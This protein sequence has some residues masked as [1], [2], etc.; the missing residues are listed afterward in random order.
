MD[1]RLI[2]TMSPADL[3]RF[4]HAMKQ[5]YKFTPATLAQ[6]I[7][8]GRWIAAR[9]L[10]YISTIVASEVNKGNA[11]I[12]VCMPARH[13]KSEFLSV[14]T[15]I[16]FLEKWPHK[17]VMNLS[18]GL[19][20]ASE[21]SL[22]VRTAF[23]DEDN[24]D[25]LNTRLRKDKLKI[26]RFMTT[27]NGGVTAAGIGGVITGRGADLLLV[28]DYIK[29]AEA[30]LSETQN[31][32]T[33]EWFK[34]TAYTRLEPGAS[35]IVLATRWGI[36]DLIGRLLKEMAHEN[37]IVIN[38]PAFA[39]ENDPLG[40]AVGEPLWPERYPTE[41]LNAIKAS[42]GAYWWEAMFQQNPR[43]SMAGADLGEQIRV[44]EESEM[45]PLHLL[46]S[47]RAWD[48]AA[49][50]SKGDYTAG[51]LLSYYPA[52]G[53]FYI[54]D[55]QHLQASPLGVEKRVVSMA[56]A[57]GPGVPI[58]LE[59]EPGSSGVIVID[60]YRRDVLTGYSVGGDKP[61]GRIEVRAS[62]LMADI[63]AGLVSMVRAPWNDRLKEE[64]NAFPDGEHDDQVSALALGHH[65]LT[66]SRFGS[67]IWGREAVEEH[68]ALIRAKA[69]YENV[70]AGTQTKS[71]RGVCWGR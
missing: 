24:H 71:T 51:P 26:D 68:T 25:L 12:I 9:H 8:R 15:P 28:D 32:N 7:T 70:N 56:T 50:Q 2:D 1:R 37:W 13:G 53:R 48:L 4:E 61:S 14:N 63:E 30:A 22:K 20:L 17:Q 21:F 11:R 67:I 44:I 49:Q 39:V 59:Q 35:I 5:G 46:R 65:K 33:M 18:Y 52:N 19:E 66:K 31:V 60:H 64:F 42:I 40:R 23:L 58:W 3:E 62:P 57:D 45:P 10:K 38:L 41:R 29:N 54:R 43:A 47:V 36:N 55:M 69:S 34:S 27:E 6:K 16:W